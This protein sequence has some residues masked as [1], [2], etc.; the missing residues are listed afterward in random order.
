MVMKKSIEK[1]ILMNCMI[2]ARQHLILHAKMSEQVF[3]SNML[4]KGKINPKGKSMQLH[5][6]SSRGL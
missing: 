5:K 3:Q 6:S 4:E 1:V 2:L